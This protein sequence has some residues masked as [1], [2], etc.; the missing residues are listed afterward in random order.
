MNSNLFYKTSIALVAAFAVLSCSLF[1]KKNANTALDA[2]Q[3]GCVFESELDSPKELGEA[4]KIFGEALP[5]LQQL[6]SQRNAARK[7]GASW[8]AVDGGSDAAQAK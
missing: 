8:R 2:I 1:T 4:C 5:L 7:A 3:L 6:I